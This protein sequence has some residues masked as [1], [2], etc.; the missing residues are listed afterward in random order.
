M[1][2]KKEND[3]FPKHLPFYCPAQPVM[4]ADDIDDITGI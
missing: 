1:K 4:M 2:M 3:V